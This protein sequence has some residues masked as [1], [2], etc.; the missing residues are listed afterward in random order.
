MCTYTAC[1][2]V[3]VCVC[4]ARIRQRQY[5]HSTT[6]YAADVIF[7]PFTVA[8]WRRFRMWHE[9][10]HIVWTH[11]WS[12]IYKYIT[13]NTCSH[14]IYFV[15]ERKGNVLCIF[16]RNTPLCKELLVCMYYRKSCRKPHRVAFANGQVTA[17]RYTCK[18]GS[19][20]CIRHCKLD[21]HNQHILYVRVW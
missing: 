6:A 19:L 17:H 9:H 15:N 3:R 16:T 1:V 7:N 14:S 2:L 8:R 4:G 5:I 20:G 11:E 21:K 10:R 12:S 13:Y 18:L